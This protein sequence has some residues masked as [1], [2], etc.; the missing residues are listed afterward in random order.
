MALPHIVKEMQDPQHPNEESKR[1]PA[2]DGITIFLTEKGQATSTEIN[3]FLKMWKCKY[4]RAGLNKL[5]KW[6]A[7]QKSISIDDSI[8]NRHIYRKGESETDNLRNIARIFAKDA[9]E[10]VM[11]ADLPH[12][13]GAYEKNTIEGMVLRWGVYAIY[14]ELFGRLRLESDPV[15]CRTE[16]YWSWVS[17]T[18]P[19][20]FFPSSFESFLQSR[21]GLKGFDIFRLHKYGKTFEIL[22]GLDKELKKLY[23]ELVSEMEAVW[24]NRE[25]MKKEDEER[26]KKLM[27]EKKFSEYQGRLEKKM[28]VRRNKKL[29]ENQCPRCFFDGTR[30]IM[31]GPQKG[32]KGEILT[33]PLR[34]RKVRHG[35]QK[36]FESGD[37]SYA[38]IC[39]QCQY[40]K[41]FHPKKS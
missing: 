19:H 31:T 36:V 33:G 21:L 8:K 22:R 13:S 10:A 37:G 24:T 12:S 34:G 23:P 7:K 4:T 2:T 16:M 32:Q 25:R 17:G 27:E 40:Y 14:M 35:F 5:L 18:H 26:E 11:K 9:G 15:E 29:K 3:E 39:P 30:M 38:R 28:D 6:M 41:W 1:I 20:P